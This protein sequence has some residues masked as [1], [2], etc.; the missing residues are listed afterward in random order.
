MTSSIIHKV[1]AQLAMGKWRTHLSY[2]NISKLALS[3]NKLYAVGNGSLYSLEKIDGT[4]E[5][6]SKITGLNGSNITQINYNNSTN[7][8]L[9]SYSDGNID[10]LGNN[11]VV[12]IPDF[13]IKQ[14]STSKDINDITFYLDKAYLS[15]QFG[16]LVINLTKYETADTYYLGWESA[17]LNILKTTIGNDSIFA[18]SKDS[19]Y[20]GPSNSN[21]L[22][23]FKSWSRLKSLPGKGDIQSIAYHNNKLIILRGGQLFARQSNYTWTQINSPSTFTKI[24]NIDN[25]LIAS[26]ATNLYEFDNNLNYKTISNNTIINDYLYDPINQTY[27]TGGTNL[28]KITSDGKLTDLPVNGPALNSPWEMTFGGNKLFVVPGG[29]WASGNNTPAY[30]M[31]FENEKWTNISPESIKNQIGID[32]FDFVN[33][34]IDPTDNKH[35]FV[36]S[37]GSG[38]FE[39]K[40]DIFSKWYNHENTIKGLESIYSSDPIFKYQ[41]IRLYGIAFDANKNLWITSSTGNE[42]IYGTKV[43]LADGKWV[44]LPY[45]QPKIPTTGSIIISNQNKNQKWS[46]SSRYTP[47]ISVF[48]D[49]GSISDTKDDNAKFLSSFINIDKSN[50]TFTPKS[51]F[52]IT[53]DKNGTIW[54][55]TDEGPLLFNS[56]SKVF[57]DNYTCSR[58]KIP[59]NDGTNQ[60]DYLLETEQINAIAIDGANRKWIGTK[61]SGAYLVSEN[62]VDIIHH[63]SS[64]NS[65]LI[66]NNILSIAINP[67]TGEVFLGSDMGL[68]SYQ[69]DAAEA[70][71][72]FGDVHAY[73]NPV[74]ENFEGIIT[75]TGLVEKAEIKITDITGN[76]VYQTVSN[77]SIATWD[78]KDGKGRKVSTGVYIALCIS[79]DGTQSTTTKILVIN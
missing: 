69:G 77:G 55:G 7:Q 14:L 61:S 12:N 5:F 62:G 42:S 22:S 4:I 35:F 67:I 24:K 43:L 11:G 65:P 15:C 50:S 63:F 16:I 64:S 51:Y 17:D 31:I 40:N 47:G 46:L 23:Y 70:N 13:S 33:V 6:Y 58:V 28:H 52:C 25:F 59:R 9:I 34:A 71:G 74:R 39:F 53:Q 18:I 21:H 48:D 44:Q 60:A 30:L 49:N 76:L 54:V 2:N 32:I 68:I 26:D 79:P 37:Y 10:V 56:L 78:G 38:L 3:N 27:W 75:I 66:S 20:C 57:D 45:P 29:R 72:S 73:P 8:L 36:S 41:Y 1:D 19:I